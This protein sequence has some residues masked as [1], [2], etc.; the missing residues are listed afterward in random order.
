MENPRTTRIL[1]WSFGAA[2]LISAVMFSFGTFKA[3]STRWYEDAPRWHHKWAW[4][5]CFWILGWAFLLGI[6]LCD[7]NMGYSFRLGIPWQVKAL[8][9]LPILGCLT[10]IPPTLALA[11]RP[12]DSK[13]FE[14][15]L[16]LCCLGLGAVFLGFLNTWNLLGFKF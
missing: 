8:F 13:P 15:P 11:R 2:L 3:K 16:F 1:L 7:L 5:L 6:R 12:R 4:I 9:I 14:L 10:L